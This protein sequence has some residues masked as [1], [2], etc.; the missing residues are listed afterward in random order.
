MPVRRRWKA[1][2]PDGFGLGGICD[3][4]P[5]ARLMARVTATVRAVSIATHNA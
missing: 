3:L 5:I 1:C 4:P 2:R